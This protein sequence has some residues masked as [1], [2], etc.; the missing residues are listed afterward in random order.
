LKHPV[1][2]VDRRLLVLPRRAEG[3]PPLAAIGI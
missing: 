3:S 1:A 2:G